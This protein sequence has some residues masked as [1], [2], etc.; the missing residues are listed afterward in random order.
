[1]EGKL[2]TN[3]PSFPEKCNLQRANQQA[4]LKDAESNDHEQFLS[5][6]ILILMLTNCVSAFVNTDVF[7]K[8]RPNTE[9]FWRFF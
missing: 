5:R 8:Y 4:L 7:S 3:L 2:A 6:K 1:M 9:Q